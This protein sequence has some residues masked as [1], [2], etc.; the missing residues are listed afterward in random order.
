MTYLYVID[1]DDVLINS[2]KNQKFV[3]MI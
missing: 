2:Y 1:N 3:K